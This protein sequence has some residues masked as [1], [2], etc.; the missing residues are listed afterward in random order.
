VCYGKS[1][2]RLLLLGTVLLASP[3]SSGGKKASTA[4]NNIPP[5]AVL[6]CHLPEE[7]PRADLVQDVCASGVRYDKVSGMWD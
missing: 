6:L 2:I 7:H 3:D 5:V 1:T 4:N